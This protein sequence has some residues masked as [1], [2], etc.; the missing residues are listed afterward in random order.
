MEI[1]YLVRREEGESEAR[2]ALRLVDSFSIDW[3]SCESSILEKASQIKSSG[4]VSVADSWV[5]ATASVFG[6]T[7]VHKDPEFDALTDITQEF[8]K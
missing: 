7:L 5:A 8:L 6:C 4:R 2:E 3:V 1:F